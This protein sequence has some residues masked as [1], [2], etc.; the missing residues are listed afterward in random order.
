MTRTRILAIDDEPA[1]RKLIS[2]ALAPDN[3]VTAV[4]SGE[5]ALETLHNGTT[6]DVILCDLMMPT[7]SGIEFYRAF[8]SEH[9]A[10]GDSIIF[11]TGGAY[12]QEARSFLSS[13]PNLKVEKPF[14]PAHLRAVVFS[15]AHRCNAH[16]RSA[17]K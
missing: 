16:V 14:D 6:F 7:M 17:R 11:L 1:L 2:R 8:H 13:V 5:E 3:D 9:P 15:H 4:A 10:E 12:S